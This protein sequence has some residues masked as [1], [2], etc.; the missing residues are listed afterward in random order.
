MSERVSVLDIKEVV[1]T[2]QSRHSRNTQLITRLNNFLATIP[3]R[4]NYLIDNRFG[5]TGFFSEVCE[6]FS[7]PKPSSTPISK[8]IAIVNLTPGCFLVLSPTQYAEYQFLH[9]NA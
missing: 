8:H 1:E 9:N 5:V 7:T 2:I 4:S 3:E 6:F